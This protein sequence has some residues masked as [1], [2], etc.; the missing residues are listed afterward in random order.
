MTPDT[1]ATPTAPAPA[2]AA[3]PVKYF[4]VVLP[5]G[6]DLRV[7]PFDTAEGLAAFLKGLDPAAQGYVFRGDR[8]LITSGPWRYLLRPDG[9]PLPLFDPPKVGKPD[10]SPSLGLRPAESP[11]DAGYASL[12]ADLDLE[13]ADAAAE[14]EPELPQA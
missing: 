2:P 9:E 5:E 14:P 10:R 3:P 8:L 12:V 11:S 6:G 7:H 4:A 1:P 13:E